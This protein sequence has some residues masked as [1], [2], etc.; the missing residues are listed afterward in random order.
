MSIQKNLLLIML[1]AF[2]SLIA[3]SF[4]LIVPQ[5]ELLLNEKQENVRNIIDGA[6]R[7]VAYQYDRFKRGE[8]TEDEARY[9]AKTLLESVRYDG[10]N[11][12]WINNADSVIVMHP[13]KPQLNGKDLSNFQDPNGKYIFREFVKAARNGS[14]FVKYHWEKPG[15][16]KPVPKLSYVSEFKPWGWTMG[17]GIYIDDVDAL[18][19]EKVIHSAIFILLATIVMGVFF[20]FIYRSIMGR[21]KATIS[22]M[23]SIA[24]TNDLTQRLDDMNG[25]RDCELAQIARSFNHLIDSLRDLLNKNSNASL[26]NVAI[27]EELYT[28]AKEIEKRILEETKLIEQADL[29]VIDIQ[30]TLVKWNEESSSTLELVAEVSGSMQESKND[31]Q[32]LN[33]KVTE[34]VEKE[35]QLVDRFNT[36]SSDAEEIKGVLGVIS[37]IADQTNLLALNA[38]IEAARAGEHGRGFAVVADEVRKLAERTQK[39]LSDINA[40]VNLI[41]Q[42]IMDATQDINTNS[43]NILELSKVSETVVERIDSANGLM[44]QV[45]QTV[46]N[47]FDNATGISNKTDHVVGN[48]NEIMEFSSFNSRSVEEIATAS[49]HLMHMVEELDKKIKTFK[50]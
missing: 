9:Q 18:F 45:D 35:L 11:Y 47:A 29:E 26:E 17:T 46:H 12:I 23:D 34:S 3:L 44:S 24:D 28:T 5:K 19:L 37:D 4:M 25:C 6:Y 1:F 20:Y 38:A 10:D 22:T 14:H 31:I 43:D 50:L 48:M 21:I 39:S 33:E 27:S 42:A 41:I 30:K 36:L 32:N 49:N 8:I 15:H 40:S 2:A 13:I 7:S 16:S